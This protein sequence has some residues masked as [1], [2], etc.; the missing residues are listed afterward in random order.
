[1]SKISDTQQQQIAEALAQRRA[2]LCAEIRTELERSGHEHYADLA[3]EVSDAGDSSVA[4]ML[5][6]RDIAIISRQVEELAQVE[7]AQQRIGSDTFGECEECGEE[8]GF[9]R[10]LAA[11]QATRCI[12][13]QS[14]HE[15]TFAHSGAPKL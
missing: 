10:L 9:Q 14:Q 13:C 5:L 12:N 1:M 3:G 11:P 4:D 2:E 8:I 15:K 6:D 7:T